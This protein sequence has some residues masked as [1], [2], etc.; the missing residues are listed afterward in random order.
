MSNISD[1][2]ALVRDREELSLRALAEAVD[3]DTGLRFAYDSVRRYES[4]ETRVPAEYVAA[5]CRTLGISAEWLLLG[6][7]SPTPTAPDVVERAFEEISDIVRRVRGL[8]ADA[9]EA[10]MVELVKG[11]WERFTRGLPPNH[12]LRE[13]IV[14]SWIRSRAAGVDHDAD[15]LLLGQISEEDL[16]RRQAEHRELIEA[17]QPHLEWLSAAVNNL[18]HVVYL[19]CTDGIVLHSVSTDPEL[20]ET[21]GLHPGHDWSEETMG[22]NGAGTALASENVVAV[23]GPEH[24]LGS[25]HGC[26]CLA[27]PIRDGGGRMIGAIDL[28]TSFSGWR[29]DRLLLVAYAA[30]MIERD[31]EPAES[32]G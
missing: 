31:L 6:E 23:L 28:S 25:A 16:E 11:E 1:R 12:R 14:E 32:D 8:D 15:K 18:S 20:L 22:T 2:L 27:A 13:A 7:G 5:V 21:W 29:P 17:G 26:S 24:Y 10:A 4:G 30:E 9:P 3:E 19:V